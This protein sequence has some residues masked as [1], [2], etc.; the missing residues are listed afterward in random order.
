[1]TTR[2]EPIAS[3]KNLGP[4]SAELLA[5]CRVPDAPTLRQLGAAEVYRRVKLRFPAQTSRNLLWALQG[6]L[7]DLHWQRLP[8][9]IKAEL[10]AEVAGAGK[11][12]VDSE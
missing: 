2:P 8:A 7:M 11:R 4:K 10:V 12:S 5:A 6:A 9:E 3:L 1:M